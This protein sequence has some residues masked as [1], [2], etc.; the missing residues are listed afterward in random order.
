[1]AK[2]T[3]TS[4]PIPAPMIATIG[5]CSPGEG[6]GAEVKLL[7]VSAPFEVL[8]ATADTVFGCA[9]PEGNIAS[10]AADDAVG[11][12]VE[13]LA[14]LARIVLSDGTDAT[15]PWEEGTDKEVG[16]TTTVLNVV[17]VD[18]GRVTTTSEVEPLSEVE[19]LVEL[20]GF[21]EVV[22]GGRGLGS[23]SL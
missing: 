15:K 23:P 19:L 9:L 20:P 10:E 17:E 21:I 3:S 14:A 4:A 1:M 5:M 11:G 13:E 6:V 18:G 12:D 16:G 8:A 7:V 2:A 22:T